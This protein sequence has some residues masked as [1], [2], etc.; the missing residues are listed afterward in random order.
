VNEEA[1]AHWGAVAPKTKKYVH[2]E[3]A[4]FLFLKEGTSEIII[5]FPRQTHFL[6]TVF[7]FI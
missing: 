3:T 7:F 6:I 4:L 1:M 2:E 5:S